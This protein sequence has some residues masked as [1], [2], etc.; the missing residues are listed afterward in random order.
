[1]WSSNIHESA[2]SDPLLI[3]KMFPSYWWYPRLLR[4]MKFLR[5]FCCSY[6][7]FPICQQIW[8]R[9]MK[10]ILYME[11]TWNSKIETT[12]VPFW[13]VFIICLAPAFSLAHIIVKRMFVDWLVND[14]SLRKM[15]RADLL[16]DQHN[17]WGRTISTSPER[18]ERIEESTILE[19][20]RRS[21][22]LVSGGF[23]DNCSPAYL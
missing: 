5:W 2:L 21:V 19:D 23:E 18:G 13:D 22:S 7:T 10:L 11:P 8:I 1:M 20:S 15:R 17:S 9:L 4:K 14:D 6:Y 16:V 3:R 12:T